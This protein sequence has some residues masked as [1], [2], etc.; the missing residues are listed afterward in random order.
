[1]GGGFS[2]LGDKRPL[3]TARVL[4]ARVLGGGTQSPYLGSGYS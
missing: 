4:T 1:M 2:V 3:L